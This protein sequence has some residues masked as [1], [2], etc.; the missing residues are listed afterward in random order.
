MPSL[1][2]FMGDTGS[3]TIG[4]IIA[5][6]AIIIHEELLI[7]ILCGIFDREPFCNLASKVFWAERRKARNNV[8]SNGHPF[9]TISVLQWH[10]WIRNVAIYYLPSQ[11]MYSRIENN[12]S[13]LDY[14]HY[15]G[16]H[17]NYNF[18]D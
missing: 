11:A 3:L 2:V 16:C 14:Y 12:C 7:P 6:F 15:I 9:T 17:Y 5:V 13:F 18:K 10:N 1:E 8:F 4:G